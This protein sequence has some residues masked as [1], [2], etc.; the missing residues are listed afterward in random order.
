MAVR[1]LKWLEALCSSQ[2]VRLSF[3]IV[4]LL[5]NKARHFDHLLQIM[6]DELAGMICSLTD[7]FG[8]DVGSIAR[9][10]A[11]E[12]GFRVFAAGWSDRRQETV[13]FTISSI[14]DASGALRLG[15]EL[16]RLPISWRH[17]RGEFSRLRR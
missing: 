4:H 16:E 7:L 17:L 2:G 10:H 12:Q 15:G 6:P 11:V 13:A 14:E 8:V 9:R 1:G 5:E 3:R